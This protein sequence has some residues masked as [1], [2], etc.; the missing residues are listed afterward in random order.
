MS[1]HTPLP[2]LGGL[3]AAEFMRDYWHRKPLLIRQAIPAF[4]PPLS[5][6]QIKTLAHQDDVESRLIWR[7]ADQWEMEE[8]PFE[9]LPPPE[10]PDWTLLVQ[11]LNLHDDASAGLLERFRFVPDARVDDLM[12]SIATDQG[13]VGPHFDSYDVFLLQGEGQRRW[14][15]SDQQNLQLDPDAPLKILSAFT[16]T[17]TFVL[18]PGDMLYLPP[19]YAH[20]GVA[21]GDCMTLSIGFRAPTA[22]ELARGL[23]EHASESLEEAPPATLLHRYQDPQ[24]PATSTPAELPAGLL[25]FTHELARQLSFSDALIQDFLGQWLTEPKANVVFP[26]PDELPDLYSDWPTH[27][28]LRC[29]RRT[30]MIYRNGALYINGECAM[31]ETS[32]SLIKF[33]DARQISCALITEEEEQ[34]LMQDWLDAGWIHFQQDA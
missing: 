25:S 28:M 30:R 10:K 11:G 6:H 15:I 26:M 27:G 14:E 7:E 8:G 18:E 31:R 19:C 16:P 17:A 2:L 24:Q 5:L 33:A 1:I 13:G 29:D 3:S 4:T 21:I 22:L 34:G 20:N 23:L 32:P 9:T 12:V